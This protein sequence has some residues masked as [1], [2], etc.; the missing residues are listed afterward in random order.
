MWLPTAEI[1]VNQAF[2][3]QIQELCKSLSIEWG[4]DEI[5]LEKI[6]TLLLQKMIL[7]VG[8]NSLGE[9]DQTKILSHCNDSTVES[10]D[11]EIA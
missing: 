8:F 3:I 11:A 5:S 9:Y 6:T 1:A 7:R 4:T 2:R 10:C